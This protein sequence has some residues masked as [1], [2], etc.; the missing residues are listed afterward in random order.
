MKSKELE[1]LI[2]DEGYAQ[3]VGSYPCARVA[4]FGEVELV[5][6]KKPVTK[7]KQITIQFDYPLHKPTSLVF[8]SKRGFTLKDLFRCVYVGY[9][10]IYREEGVAPMIPG[11]YNRQTS[12]GK[13][14]IWGHIMEDLYLEGMREVKPGKFELSIGS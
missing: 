4:E 13:Y 1:F 6:A 5:D 3:D 10:K 11:M 2:K 14:G 7:R 12:N 8:K 9:N